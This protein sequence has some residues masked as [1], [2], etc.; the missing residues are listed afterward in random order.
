M[1]KA[2]FSAPYWKP[3]LEPEKNPNPSFMVDPPRLVRALISRR[4]SRMASSKR[5]AKRRKQFEANRETR[6]EPHRIE[7]FHQLDDPYSHLTAQVL[8]RFSERYD[9]A[10]VPHLVRASGGKNQPEL[11]KLAV[12]ARRDCGL[13]ASHFG[14]TFPVT[15]AKIPVRQDLSDA[16]SALAGLSPGAFVDKIKSVSETLW[17]GDKIE[18][19]AP[20]DAAE[21]AIDEGSNRLA[22]LGHYSGAT[23]YYGGEFYWGVDRLFHLEQRLMNLGLRKDGATDFLVPRPSIDVSGVDASSLTLHFY[24]SL[25]SPYT[26]IIFDRTIVLAKDCNIKLEHKPV[27]PMIMRGVPATNAKGSYILFDTKREADFF[28]VPFGPVFTPIGT[29]TR[30]AYSLIPWAKMQGKDT[31]LMSA[32]LRLAFAEGVSLAREN[33]LR[34]AV[35]EAGLNWAEAIKVVGSDDW[36]PMIE[37]FQNEMVEGMGLWGVPSYRLT[38][39]E[40]EP[41]LEVW[42]QD[43]LWLVAA[44]IRRRA[45]D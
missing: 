5:I 16:A 41:D 12:W 21:I 45:V 42:G 34:K 8:S 25:N 1:K 14:L 23:F 6:G 18:T 27:L 44:E 9:V 24:P 40:G 31:D 4:L 2:A 3:V 35:E 30:R 29:P 15:A 39:P 19:S 7:Y 37:E 11:E 17:S 10:V 32:L 26:S 43:R 13:V 22:K 28:G 20:A 33:G 38:G 36:K